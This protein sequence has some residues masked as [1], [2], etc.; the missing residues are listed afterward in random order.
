MMFRRVSKVTVSVLGIVMLPASA[1]AVNVSANDGNGEQHRTKTYANGADVT[2]DLRS[3]SGKTVYYNCE[4]PST[5]RYSTNTSSTSAVT[6]GGTIA[7]SWFIT[8]PCGFQGVKSRVC[9][10]KTGLPDP[11]GPDSSTY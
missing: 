1:W 6:R 10:V 2:G 4:D 8:P 11:C 9:T 3:A 7:T 5:G